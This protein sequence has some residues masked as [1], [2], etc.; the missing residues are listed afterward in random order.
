MKAYQLVSYD[1]PDGLRLV[2]VPAPVP[3]PDDLLVDVSAIGINYPD[4]LLTR[5]QYQLRP[6]LPCIPG[7]EI[8]GTVRQAPAGSA[9]RSGDHV[10]A[11]VWQGGF[12]EQALIPM[13]TAARVPDEVGAVVAAAS[14]VN[15]HTVLFAL[16]RRARL[17]AGERV[18]VLGAAGGIGTAAIQIARGLGATVVA[19]V[20]TDDQVAVAEK[21]GADEVLVLE[22]GF[23]ARVRAGGRGVDLVVDPVGDWLFDE[24]LRCLEPE[25]RLAVIGFAAGQIP[26]VA[27]NRLLLRN[28]AVIGAAFGAF[29]DREPAL[30]GRQAERIFS[31]AEQGFVNPPVDR[32]VGFDAL[33]QTLEALGRG[34]VRGKAVVSLR[35]DS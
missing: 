20:A 30:V 21:A 14:T 17:T 32:V 18:L 24:A 31:L 26:T 15:Y 9:W 23:A 10:S 25:G 13:A 35:G 6:E 7:C 8:A 22:P 28:V 34:E 4:L 27:V 12:A 3:G 16:D 19:G 5:G 2:D 33:P 29:L 11:F 1:G